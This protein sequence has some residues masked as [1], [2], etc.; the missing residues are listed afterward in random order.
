MSSNILLLLLLYKIEFTVIMATATMLAAEMRYSPFC[1]P[2]S[3]YRSRSIAMVV[4]SETT[5]KVRKPAAWRFEER[6]KPR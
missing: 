6:S 3:K 2:L 1:T 5:I 4:A